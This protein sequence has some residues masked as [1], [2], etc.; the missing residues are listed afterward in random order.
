[1]SANL[2]SGRQLVDRA[3]GALDSIIENSGKVLESIRQVTQSSEEQAETTQHIGRNI[4]T[5]S[6][7][8]HEAASGN[9]TIASA[10]QEMS[11]L[12][13]D[14]QTRVA[15]FHLGGESEQLVVEKAEE[16]M[17]IPLT[18]APAVV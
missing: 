12:I 9:Q 1:V 18:R 11:A 16:A 4:E 5:I 3:G 2:A 17:M 15:R 7:V 10:V 14:L 8:T 13:E 6:R